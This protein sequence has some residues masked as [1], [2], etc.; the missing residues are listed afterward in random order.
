MADPTL[1]AM[2]KTRQSGQNIVPLFGKPVSRTFTVS[3]NLP[4]FSISE[5]LD[6]V[7]LHQFQPL[8]WLESFC[9]AEVGLQASVVGW[10]AF[11]HPR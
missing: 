11:V 2:S 7:Q 3:R 8:S 5:H 10:P 6:Q 4:T 9:Q 1:M